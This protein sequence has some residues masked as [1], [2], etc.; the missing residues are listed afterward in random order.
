MTQIDLPPRSVSGLG[1][2][3]RVRADVSGLAFITFHED[4]V[5]RHP[6]VGRIVQAYERAGREG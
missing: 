6:L 5:I 1:E 2:A 3:G 4:D